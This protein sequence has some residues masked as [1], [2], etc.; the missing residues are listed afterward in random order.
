MNEELTPEFKKIRQK[1]EALAA[2]YRTVFASHEGELVLSDLIRR[3]G[4]L[5]A[6]QTTDP[7]EALIREGERRMGLHIFRQVHNSEESLKKRLGQ[8]YGT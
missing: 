2:A 3:S 7:H 5:G 1:A 4:I 6:M 8:E